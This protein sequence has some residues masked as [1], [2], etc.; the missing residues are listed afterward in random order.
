MNY[1][2]YCGLPLDRPLI[3]GI[4]TCNRCGRVFDSSDKNKLLSASWLVRREH[5]CDTNVI[6]FRTKL[7]KE[8]LAPV[9]KYVVDQGYCHDDFLKIIDSIFV[10]DSAA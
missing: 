2:P 7:S 4:S 6:E 9:L 3:D 8:E 10:V 5:V 1:C